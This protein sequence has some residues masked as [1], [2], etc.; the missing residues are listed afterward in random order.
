[1]ADDLRDLQEKLKSCEEQLS[2]AQKINQELQQ[3]LKIL[4]TE[5]NTLIHSIKVITETLVE[6][7]RKP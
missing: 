4:E 7:I 1:M 2:G 5:R 3:Y 6:S